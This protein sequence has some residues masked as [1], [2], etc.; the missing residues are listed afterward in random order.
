MTALAE[1]WTTA[2]PQHVCRSDTE[3]AGWYV[4]VAHYDS[5]PDQ[6]FL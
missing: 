1:Q 6:V 4:F 2:P 5:V 3:D